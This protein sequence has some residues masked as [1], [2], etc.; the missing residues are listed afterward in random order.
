MNYQYCPHY[1]ELSKVVSENRDLEGISF[2]I[3]EIK[4]CIECSKQKNGVCE[5]WVAL[6]FLHDMKPQMSI[7]DKKVT[8]ELLDEQMKDI[9]LQLVK[10]AGTKK[11]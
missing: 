6:S 1:N 7:P 11:E 4:N 2:E 5:L 8:I 9:T 3:N 10:N